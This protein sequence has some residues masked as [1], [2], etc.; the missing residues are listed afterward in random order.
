MKQGS[1]EAWTLSL[2]NQFSFIE[3]NKEI[4]YLCQ[5]LYDKDVKGGSIRLGVVL[6]DLGRTYLR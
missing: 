4:A 5:Q 6:L 1:P 2:Q 3:Y